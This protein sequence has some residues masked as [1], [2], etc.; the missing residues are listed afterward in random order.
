[1][2]DVPDNTT[3]PAIA[4]T[5]ARTC[6]PNT[7]LT[8]SRKNSQEPEAKHGQSACYHTVSRYH[9]M[10]IRR[11]L[12]ARRSHCVLF[13]NFA[14]ERS[15]PAKTCLVTSGDAVQKHS[16]RGLPSQLTENRIRDCD[17]GC[18]IYLFQHRP[19]CC[20]AMRGRGR[21]RGYVLG[22]RSPKISSWASFPS[23]SEYV[24]G[25][26]VGRVACQCRAEQSRAHAS[27]IS[28]PW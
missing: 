8:S 2:N 27:S 24:G 28:I 5:T 7:P 19:C 20:C 1:V 22:L 23:R 26:R 4:T 12:V 3:R 21:G 16:K 15:T 9:H 13:P 14:L 6:S 17:M 10:R 25:F 11:K 18:G